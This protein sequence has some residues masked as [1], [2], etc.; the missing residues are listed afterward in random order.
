MN[1]MTRAREKLDALEAL[2][3]KE[4]IERGWKELSALCGADSRPK[5][6]TMTVPVDADRDSDI[7]FGEILMRFAKLEAE[8]KE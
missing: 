8:S 1:D 7:L 2:G 3:N 5:R 6:W 4:L